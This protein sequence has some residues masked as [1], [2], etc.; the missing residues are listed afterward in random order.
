MQLQII[1]LLNY[2]MANVM[3]SDILVIFLHKGCCVVYVCMVERIYNI[4]DLRLIIPF[5]FSF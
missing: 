2:V 3:K 5:S 1:L 4:I